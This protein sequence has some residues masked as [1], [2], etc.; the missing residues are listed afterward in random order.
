[1]VSEKCSGVV[2]EC[3]GVIAIHCHLVIISGCHRF[4]FNYLCDTAVQIHTNY[5]SMPLAV[6]LH[7]P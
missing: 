4:P 1:M 3:Q 5:L 2:C 7:S 6:Y